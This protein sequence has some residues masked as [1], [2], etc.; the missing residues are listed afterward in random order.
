MFIIDLGSHSVK[1]GT[2]NKGD[3]SSDD[4]FSMN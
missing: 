3:D 2:L 4:L 1:I